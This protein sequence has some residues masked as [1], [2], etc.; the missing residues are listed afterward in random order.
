MLKLDFYDTSDIATILENNCRSLDIELNDTVL[1]KLAGKSRGTP[2]IAN[3]LLKILRD[4]HTI[5]KNISDI[6]VLKEI[7][8][9]IGIDEK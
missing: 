5:G 7:F 3:R 6:E 1:H 4:Y 9:D 8:Q 2:R